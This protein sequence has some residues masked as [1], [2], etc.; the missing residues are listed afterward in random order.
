[1]DGFKSGTGNTNLLKTNDVALV[2][3]IKVVLIPTVIFT[4]DVLNKTVNYVCIHSLFCLA[5]VRVSE[6]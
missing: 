3:D 4:C 2:F 1:M 6:F 5:Q